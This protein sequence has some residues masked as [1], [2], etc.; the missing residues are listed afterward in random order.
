M[1]KFTIKFRPRTEAKPARAKRG[2]DRATWTTTIVA[3]AVSA[4]PRPAS[5]AL[6]RAAAQQRELAKDSILPTTMRE[7]QVHAEDFTI[8]CKEA[9]FPPPL[10]R[11]P[12]SAVA[13]ASF[14]LAKARRN[15]NAR[16][17][18]QW[19]AK[20]LAYFYN[21]WECPRLSPED[22]A[23]LVSQSRYAK[24]A[25]G[26][27]PS[28]LIPAGDATLTAIWR[29]GGSAI[30]GNVATLM[31]WR[32]L[33]IAKS[34]T[35]RPED[36]YGT[37]TGEPSDRI[38]VSDV[39]FRDPAPEKGLPLGYMEVTLR[40]SKGIKLTGRGKR[41]GELH[42]C[43]ATGGDMCPVGAMRAIFNTY[44]LHHPSRADEFVFA[45]MHPSGI[46]KYS[47]P[48]HWKGAELIS[49]R[50]Y[51]ERVTHTC[52]LGNEPRFTGKCTRHGSS[53]DMLLTGLP[54]EVSDVTGAWKPGSQAPYQR[55]TASLAGAVLA[56]KVAHEQ[57]RTIAEKALT[58]R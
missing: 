28:I 40:S 39:A 24:K 34:L 7:N 2:R 51:N 47:D 43:G 48:A 54:R 26:D 32:Q 12:L 31:V 18:K 8:H 44:G 36:H 57:Q 10:P 46:R 25:Y 35:L 27:N 42:I 22:L 5:T 19:Q 1:G 16:S 58:G 33:L 55:M 23:H 13:L 37:E 15:N 4:A 45:A 20:T 9:G 50:E 52:K 11:E 14:F 3:A 6:E 41:D 38:K 17:W 29:K 21:I 56:A 30:R 53:T 49:A